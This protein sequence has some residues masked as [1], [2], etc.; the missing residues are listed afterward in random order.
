MRERKAYWRPARFSEEEEDCLVKTGSSGGKLGGGGI[1]QE[2]KTY[3]RLV[4]RPGEEEDG[5]VKAK[6]SG[7]K[8]GGGGRV[9][10][11]GRPTGDQLVVS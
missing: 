3:W 7:G 9:E 5:R 6:S 10:E 4:R 8:L 11:R 1:V 2:T